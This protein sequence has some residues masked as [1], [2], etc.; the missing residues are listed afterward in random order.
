MERKFSEAHVKQFTGEGRG[1]AVLARLGVRDKDGDVLVPGLLGGEQQAPL[2]QAHDWQVPPFGR[3]VVRERGDELVAD[4][5]LNLETARGREWASVLKFDLERG[6]LQQWS[7]AFTVPP[8]GAETGMHGGASARLLKRI[9]L[10]EVSPV[11][12]GASMG[13]RTLALKADRV[14]QA[15]FKAMETRIF[16]RMHERIQRLAL[17]SPPDQVWLT[18]MHARIQQLGRV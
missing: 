18:A 8:G 11:V 4:F 14:A 3:A 17:K 6:P 9:Q 13:S 15:T 12:V 16:A 1:A 2:I 10:L 7:W 5:T